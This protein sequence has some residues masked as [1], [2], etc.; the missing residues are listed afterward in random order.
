ML[1]DQ[2]T[3][4]APA[5]AHVVVEPSIL[6][7]GTPVVL[8]STLNPDGS[9]NLAPMSSAWALGYTI[10]LGLG[11][12]GQTVANLKRERECVLNFPSPELWQHVERL[13]PLTGANP[14]PPQKTEKFHYEPRKF[15]AAGLTPQPSELVQPPRVSEC[16]IQLEAEV[17]KVHSPASADTFAIVETSVTRVHVRGDLITPG[18]QHIDPLQWSPLLYTFRHYFGASEH[19]GKTFRSEN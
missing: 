18:T 9:A 6:Y 10:V 14:V 12:G 17:A 7:F 3:T 1:K 2:I 13:A 16:P 15:E 5:A 8:I 19:L 4:D 11:G